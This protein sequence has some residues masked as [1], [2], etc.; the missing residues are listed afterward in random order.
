LALIFIE[1]DL[2][3]NCKFSYTDPPSSL[4]FSHLM[5]CYDER[6][7]LQYGFYRQDI[8][9]VVHKYLEWGDLYQGFGR[10]KWPDCQHEYLVAFS[11]CGRWF[12]SLALLASLSF[13]P[14]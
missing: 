13:L 7:R 4:T 8:S 5:E 14:K 2:L 6:C 9:N 12:R 11:F 10:I 1:G 3:K